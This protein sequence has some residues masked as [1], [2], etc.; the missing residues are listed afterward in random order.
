[1]SNIVFTISPNTTGYVFSDVFSLAYSDLSSLPTSLTSNPSFVPSFASLTANNINFT[2]FAWDFGDGTVAYNTQQVTKTYTYPGTYTVSVSGWLPTGT[3]PLVAQDTITVDYAYQNKIQLIQLPNS[4]GA[5]GHP[6][7]TPF[8]VSLTCTEI[9]KPI[10][11]VLQALNS[12]STPYDSVPNKWNFISP[13]WHFVNADTNE[14]SNTITVNTVP[15]YAQDIYGNSNIV[16]VSGLATFYYVDTVSTD[17]DASPI[18]IIATLDPSNFIYPPESVHYPYPSYANSSGA[19]VAAL[20]RVNPYAPTSLKVTENYINDIYPQ[21]WTGIPIP[22]M[23]TTYFDSNSNPNFSNATQL[24]ANV[25]E[26]PYSNAN[27][28][29]YPLYLSL[30]SSDE[31]ISEGD[32]VVDTNGDKSLYF[33]VTDSQNNENMGYVFTT[34]TPTISTISNTVVTALTYTKN[35]NAQALSAKQQY[36]FPRGYP[37]YSDAYVSNPFTGTINKINIVSTPVGD[38]N[39]DYYRNLGV[40]SDGVITTLNIPNLTAGSMQAGI[41]AT[42]SVNCLAFSPVKNVL[43]ATDSNQDLVLS[44]DSNGNLLKKVS[45]Y[46]YTLSSINVPSCISVDSQSNVWIAL[47]NTKTIVKLDSDLNPL[48]AIELPFAPSALIAPPQVEVDKQG[49]VWVC[50]ATENNSYLLKYAESG[51][52]VLQAVDYNPYS[53]PVSLAID[54]NNN[55]WVANSQT[56]TVECYSGDTGLQLDAI[57]N[58]TQPDYLNFDR[59][60]NLWFVHGYDTLTQYNPNALP[61]PTSTTIQLDVAN[62]NIGSYVDEESTSLSANPWGGFT[63]D[64]YDRIWLINSYTNNILIFNIQE[65]RNLRVLGS[66]PNYENNFILNPVYSPLIASASTPIAYGDWTGN[67]WYQK[68]A[69]PHDNDILLLGSSAPFLISDVNRT[70]TVAKVNEEKDMSAYFKSL[71]LPESMNQNTDFW[72][73]FMLAVAGDGDVL[74]ESAGRII[75]ERIANFVQTH[76]DFETSE[77]DQLLS[78]AKQL[79]VPANSY[80]VDYPREI[81]RLLSL[82]SVPKHLLRGRYNYDTDPANNTGGVILPGTN[83]S[84]GEYIVAVDRQFGTYQLIYVAPLEDGTLTY[85]LSSLEVPGLRVPLEN[86]YNIFEWSPALVQGN[87]YIDNIINWNSDYTTV[88]YNL[89]SNEAWYGDLGL[90]ENMFNSAITRNIFTPLTKENYIPQTVITLKGIPITWNSFTLSYTV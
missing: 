20:W 77:I 6:S 79:S 59:L 30:S 70:Y 46:N 68:F 38:S 47:Y 53:V 26:Y 8:V 18:L 39:I 57:N 16:A 80:S 43:Y 31:T 82:F 75:Y 56:N 84:A 34:V 14:I 69:D 55:I 42:D 2:E 66:L 72:D 51:Q 23:V 22:V 13:T 25:L 27:G 15:I 4:F 60:G 3:T 76:G 12:P 48:L 85:P 65:P 28:Q 62:S 1:M 88:D 40:L 10:N 45:V 36:R 37:I 33:S 74:S 58:V 63:I 17:V 78:F 90:I 44:Y 71:A 86:N 49:N 52:L 11:V 64:V 41:S 32:C 9:Q 81:N 5:P 89:S 29:L 24:T 67:R 21:K 7:G 19:S 83:I 35:T 54:I 61:F 73:Q 50:Y 87:C